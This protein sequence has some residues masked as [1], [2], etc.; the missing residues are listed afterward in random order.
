M[1]RLRALLKAIWP[2][3]ESVEN[4]WFSLFVGAL[5]ALGGLLER[6][7]GVLKLSPGKYVCYLLR[8][9]LVFLHMISS[10]LSFHML[11]S[12]LSPGDFLRSFFC[13]RQSGEDSIWTKRVH[14]LSSPPAPVRNL[15]AIFSAGSIT[16]MPGCTE[17]TWM[18]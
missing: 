14:M 3:S 5:A 18:L 2:D 7:G 11:S 8:F 17:A 16:L 15:Y 12:P 10:P 1:E 6:L 9:R 13:L 4:H